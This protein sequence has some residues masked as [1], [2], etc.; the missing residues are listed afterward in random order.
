M[1][2]FN[3]DSFLHA[4]VARLVQKW[5]VAVAVETGTFQGHTAFALATM[6]VQVFTIEKDEERFKEAR[7]FFDMVPWKNNRIIELKGSSPDIIKYIRPMVTGERILFYLDAHWESY[8]PLQDE[9]REIAA[10]D[11]PRPVIVIH[12]FLVPGRPDLGFDHYNG[13]DNCLQHVQCLLECIYGAEFHYH[14][15]SVAIG[16]SRGVLFVEP[17]N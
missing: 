5:S 12:D 14:Y 3:G 16:A 13:N 4:E 15:N 2:P 9:L 11:G 10:F 8:W 17:E 6:C 7:A 1:T